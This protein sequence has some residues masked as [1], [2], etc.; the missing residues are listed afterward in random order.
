MQTIPFL[1]QITYHR[2]P[3][4]NVTF[5]FVLFMGVLYWRI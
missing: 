5:I 4:T 1:L 2:L 3:E